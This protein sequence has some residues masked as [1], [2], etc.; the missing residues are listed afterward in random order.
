MVPM[1]SDELPVEASGEPVPRG[2]ESCDSCSS[3]SEEIGAVYM[4]MGGLVDEMSAAE[5]LS[6]STDVSATRRQRKQRKLRKS[7]NPG[8]GR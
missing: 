4:H 7:K 3:G 8:Q 2:T 5:T 1:D 6:F